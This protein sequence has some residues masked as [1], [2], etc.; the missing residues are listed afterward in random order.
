[1]KPLHDVAANLPA[2]LIATGTGLTVVPP[3]WLELPVAN[4][5]VGIAI[6]G[7]GVVLL[8]AGYYDRFES[9][10]ESSEYGRFESEFEPSQDDPVTQTPVRTKT[11]VHIARTYVPAALVTIGAWLMWGQTSNPS[12]TIYFTGGP[13]ELPWGAQPI[14]GGAL[15]VSSVVLW[16]A[17]NHSRSPFSEAE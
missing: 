3:A 5:Q 9:E 16:L 15:I 6:A 13:H 17:L 2:L 4:R 8:Y 12:R 1:M 14:L 7:L 11:H 10:S